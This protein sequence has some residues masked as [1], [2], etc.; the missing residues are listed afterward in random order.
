MVRR[1]AFWPLLAV[2]AA[3]PA[4]RGCR[5]L[6]TGID[7]DIHHVPADTLLVLSVGQEYR[8]ADGALRIAFLGVRSDSRCPA[9]VMCIWAGNAEAEIGVAF[10][11]GPTVPYVLNTGLG[12]RS[13]DLG[14]SRLTLVDLRPVPVSTSRIPPDGYVASLRLQRIAL[15]GA[16]PRT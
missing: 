12:V 10:G 16:T 6:G 1:R 8:A 3:A 13:V 5:W 7:A 11:M 2:L 4:L 15:A 9:D 14:T